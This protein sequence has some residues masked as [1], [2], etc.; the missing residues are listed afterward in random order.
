LIPDEINA[1]EIL[2]ELNRLGWLDYKIEIECGFAKGYV[3]H[4]R[5][6]S[7]KVPGYCNAAKLMNL[8]ERERSQ[9]TQSLMQSPGAS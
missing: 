6:G 9:L 4:L 1:V 5:N 8:L 7:V 2:D 3:P